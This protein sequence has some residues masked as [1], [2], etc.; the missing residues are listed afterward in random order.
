[1]IET[2]DNAKDAI[3][4]IYYIRCD[5]NPLSNQYAA[6]T[7]AIEALEQ[8]TGHWIEFET[9][10]YKC[11]KCGNKVSTA[12]NPYEAFKYCSDCGV[13]MVPEK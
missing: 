12:K 7:W 8:K 2:I 3:K 4:E 9:E 10:F 1:M 13:R 5:Y 11:S 6:L